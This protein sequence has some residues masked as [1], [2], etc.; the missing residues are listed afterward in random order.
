MLY[1]AAEE[2]ENPPRLSSPARP[3]DK[4]KIKMNKE[5]S[6]VEVLFHDQNFSKYVVYKY[7]LFGDLES[8]GFNL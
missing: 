6:E 2:K 7:K 8:K 5:W 1:F 3:Y 4:G